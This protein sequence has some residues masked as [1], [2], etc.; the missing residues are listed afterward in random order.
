MFWILG[1]VGQPNTHMIL[2]IGKGLN[3]NILYFF[4]L[5]VFH[6][7]FKIILPYLLVIK[8]SIDKIFM[9]INQ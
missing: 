6:L 9:V 2:A 4:I 5:V 1:K 3:Q 8:N 7:D